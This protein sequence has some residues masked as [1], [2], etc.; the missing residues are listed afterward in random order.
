VLKG[1]EWRVEDEKNIVR[2]KKRI[3]FG[4]LD[5]PLTFPKELKNTNLRSNNDLFMFNAS[6]TSIDVHNPEKGAR[7]EVIS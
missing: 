7:K 6:G 2:I 1:I 5:I 3:S 4:I